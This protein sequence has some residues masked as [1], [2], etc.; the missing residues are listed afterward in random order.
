MSSP[1]LAGLTIADHP[2]RWQ[3]LGFAV[4]EGG[5]CELDGVRLALGAAGRGIT[6]WSLSGVAPAEQIDGLSTEAV[7]DRNAPGGSAGHPNGAL[8]LDHVVVLSPSYDRTAAALDAVGLGLKRERDGGGFRQGFRR[9]G[10]AILELVEAPSASP[11]PARFWGLV[12]IV[13]DLEALA[14]QLGDRLRS[15]HDAV[16]S[17]RRIATLS[18]R[19]GLS[20]KLAF[21]T[22]DP[23]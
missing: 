22:P 16:Q 6:S 5:V 10:P 7:T 8:A 2:E 11:G 14:A 15:V 3:A 23:G 21:M 19:A 13:S 1:R 18:D 17:G 20:V 9:I 12:V 4:G